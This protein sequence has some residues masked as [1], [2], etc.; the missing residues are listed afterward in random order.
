M[1]LT[2]WIVSIAFTLNVIEAAVIP[3]RHYANTEQ[4][5]LYTRSVDAHH[6]MEGD[7]SGLSLGNSDIQSSLTKRWFGRGRSRQNNYQQSAQ[8]IYVQQPAQSSGPGIV[9]TGINALIGAVAA[10]AVGVRIVDSDSSKKKEEEEGEEEKGGEKEEKTEDEGEEK[11]DEEEEGVKGKD[12]GKGKGKDEDEDT[13]TDGEEEEE[14]KGKGKDKGGKGK[15]KDEDEETDGEE[16]EEVKGK[17]KVEG[18]GQ[19]GKGKEKE[20]DGNEED[21]EDDAGDPKDESEDEDLPPSSKGKA[22]GK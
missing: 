16:E 4:E 18:K 3:N 11:T 22:K 17:G 9:R 10:R 6:L 2:I 20:K 15:G 14:V 19:G 7:A 1:K 12:K 21:G 8:P 13:E 5:R